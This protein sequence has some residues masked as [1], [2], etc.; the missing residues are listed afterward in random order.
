MK[1]SGNYSVNSYN[2]QASATKAG[3]TVAIGYIPVV[4]DALSFL[5]IINDAYNNITFSPMITISDTKTICS[6]SLTQTI[7]YTYVKD[8]GKTNEKLSLHSNT[9]SITLV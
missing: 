3:I 6:Y 8:Y 5:Q 7:A 2:F 9:V 4:G 1:K